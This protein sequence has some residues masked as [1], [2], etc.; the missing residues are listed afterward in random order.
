MD[1]DEISLKPIATKGRYKLGKIGTPCPSSVLPATHENR[2][3]SEIPEGP[4][5]YPPLYIVGGLSANPCPGAIPFNKVENIILAAGHANALGFPLEYHLVVHWL[6]DDDRHHTFLREKIAEWQGYHVGIGVFVW[7]K[8]TTSGPHSHFL[9]H[10]PRHLAD[11]FR[12]LARRWIKE[13]SGVKRLPT[14]AFSM[15]RINSHGDPY[16]HIRNRV[17]Y[18]LK[19]TD[20]ATRLVLGYDGKTERGFINGKRVGV[21]QALGEEARRKAGGVRLSGHRKPTQE[22]LAAATIRDQRREGFRESFKHT[23]RTMTQAAC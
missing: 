19:G 10:V 13:V 9:L 14:G 5:N 21:S 11:S 6:F 4:A 3:F 8:E 2:G 23:D 7:A 16:E 12:K 1:L 18:I 22:M 20:D 15:T 17:R